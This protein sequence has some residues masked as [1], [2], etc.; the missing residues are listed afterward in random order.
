MEMCKFRTS[1]EKVPGQ[2]D[3]GQKKGPAFQLTP[4][5]SGAEAGI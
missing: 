2:G 5:F 1:G 4:V 3:G